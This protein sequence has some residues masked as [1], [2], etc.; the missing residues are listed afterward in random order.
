MIFNL[1][2]QMFL[3]LFPRQPFRHR[4]RFQHAVHLEPE[5]V[6]EPAR[7]VFLN[8]E[9]ARAFYQ[10]RQR[11]AARFRRDLEVPFLFVFR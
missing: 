4:P 7:V 3:S 8:Y 2:G 11:L 1:N 5:I 9:P 10:F 6:V